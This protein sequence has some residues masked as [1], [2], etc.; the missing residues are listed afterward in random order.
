[1][2]RSAQFQTSPD[3]D[4]FPTETAPG[5]TCQTGAG[6][7]RLNATQLRASLECTLQHWN[8][9]DDCWVFAYGSLIWKP[10]F[11][12][13]ESRRT[14]VH[15][16]HRRLCLWSQINR[17]TREQPGLVLAL[18]HGG[19]CHGMAYRI[20]AQ[21]VEE[22]FFKLWQR[23]MITG[24]Y[25]PTWLTVR[26]NH[27]E[28]H[29]AAHHPLKALGFVVRRDQPGYAGKLEDSHIC[30]VLRHAHGH[31]G[32]TAEYVMRTAQ[33]LRQLGIVDRTLQRL[34]LLA[35]EPSH[36]LNA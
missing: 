17:G 15:G 35:Q 7:R 29:Q 13:I 18:D 34:A 33:S 22:A 6:D 1:M 28:C 2:D 21:D 24:D 8:G 11:H 14:T 16:Y 26:S 31:C 5:D 23:E 9:R 20:P 27:G 25:Q 36:D 3:Q 12:Y 32:S 19:C 4:H 30:N 10:E